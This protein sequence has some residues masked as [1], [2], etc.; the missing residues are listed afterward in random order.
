[1]LE[2]EEMNSAQPKPVRAAATW[3]FPGDEEW[4]KN[5]QNQPI[6]SWAQSFH[7]EVDPQASEPDQPSEPV[8]KKGILGL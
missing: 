7:W 1:M 2:N 4:E 3:P 6:P 8:G 5:N